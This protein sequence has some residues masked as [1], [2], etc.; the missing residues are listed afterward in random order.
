MNDQMQKQL[1]VELIIPLAKS[2]DTLSDFSILSDAD[3]YQ[4][5]K[6]YGRSA[7][8]WRQKFMGLLPEV[9]RR[10]LYEKHK[11]NSIFEFAYC[12]AGLN[13]QQVRTALN[14][15]KQLSDK[16]TLKSLFESGKVSMHKIVRVKSVATPEN[17]KEWADVVQN[18]SQSTVETLV[19]DLRTNECVRTNG[20]ECASNSCQNG[21]GLPKP[22]FEVKSLRAQDLKFTEGTI[23][24][25]LKLQEKGI[26]IDELISGFLDQR[27]NEIEEEKQEISKEVAEAGPT[28]SRYVQ[29]KVRNILD[30][31]YGTKCSAPG[32]NKPSMEIHHT[33]PFAIG[34]MHDP[35][36]LAPLCKE[37]HQIA[38]LVNLKYAEK[39]RK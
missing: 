33:L 17:E 1:P 38:H 35:R 14:L 18:C 10:R 24:K 8:E 12:L 9:E 13:K 31:E 37:H 30:K 16:P 22:L 5:A 36:F 20:C 23:E 7:I 3:L 29:K 11:F 39:L 28:D 32:C 27:E 34:H 15:D 25:L 19:R 21:N 6:F 26:N 2:T 4:K